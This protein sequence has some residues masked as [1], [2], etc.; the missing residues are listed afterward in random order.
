MKRISEVIE[1]TEFSLRKDE[2]VSK[3]AIIERSNI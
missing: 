3:E 1:Q 2:N